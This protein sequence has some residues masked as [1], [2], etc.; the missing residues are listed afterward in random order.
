MEMKLLVERI[1]EV[2]DF[3]R[4]DNPDVQ[5]CEKS[6]SLLI[7][8]SGGGTKIFKGIKLTL[9]DIIYVRPALVFLKI[10]K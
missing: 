4:P 5:P 6:N 3:I 1:R 8:R 9:E 10:W 2:E 7:K